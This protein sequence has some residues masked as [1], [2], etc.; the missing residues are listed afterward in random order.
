MTDAVL[1]VV[2]LGA[3]AIALVVVDL[4]A[5]LSWLRRRWE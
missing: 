2:V 1:M 3:V 5:L 4:G